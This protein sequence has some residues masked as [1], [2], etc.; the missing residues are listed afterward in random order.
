MK[1]KQSIKT[2]IDSM[3]Y[4]EMLAKWRF[5]PIGDRMMTG[6]VGEYFEKV[7][8]IKKQQCDNVAVSK[9]VGWDG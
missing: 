4:N 5:A 8:K 6:D 9:A 7:M 1:I 3:S 2:K